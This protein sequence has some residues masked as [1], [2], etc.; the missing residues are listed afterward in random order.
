M[1]ETTVKV[2]SGLSALCCV[3]ATLLARRKAR[4]QSHESNP[5]KGKEKD[6]SQR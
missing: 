1:S 6:S 3:I 5:S 4:K 2:I